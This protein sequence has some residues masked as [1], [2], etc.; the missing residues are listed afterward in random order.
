[1]M[2]PEAIKAA[3][4]VFLKTGQLPPGMGR[5]TQGSPDRNAILNEAQQQ[6]AE[7]GVAWGDVP[8]QWQQFKSQQTG[9][10]RFM[11]G[12]QGDTVRSLNVAVDHVETLRGLADAMQ[13]GNI[14]AFNSIAQEWAK[15]TGSAAP[16]NME[17]AAQ[18]V[19]TEVVKAIGVAGAG[20]KDEREH[21]A[22]AFGKASS[23]EQIHSAIDQVVAPLL[24]G[25][26]RGLRGQFKSATGLPEDRF[27]EQLLPTTRRFLEGG[28]HQPAAS[29]GMPV[30][31]QS[32]ADATRL[33]PGTHY[34]TP[35]GREFTR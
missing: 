23:P 5:G 18:I 11:S 10:T 14:R 21:I 1:M 28:G 29:A 15:Q 26:L 32:P 25:Q 20:T 6:A 3:G 19:G 35:D 24:A 2:T 13:N 12:K 30:R 31:V 9:I 16:T 8:K 33:A 27:N 4:T 34:V 22:A 7:Q 17:T